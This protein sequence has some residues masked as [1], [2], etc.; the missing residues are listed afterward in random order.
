MRMTTLLADPIGPGELMADDVLLG[1]ITQN[2]AKHEDG[3]RR[4]RQSLRELE[5]RLESN[6]QYLKDGHLAAKARL[7]VLEDHTKQPVDAA[8]LV[9]TPRVV[10]GIVT[11]TIAIAGG[12][13]ASTAGLRSDVRDIL[14]R[15]D[16]QRT[17]Y[18]A[19]AKLQ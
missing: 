5:E 4:L 18:E 17:T 10:L 15:M 19:T 2:D 13:W 1:M 11:V 8:R 3:H 9:M 12:L 7:D 16:A 14:T 6:F